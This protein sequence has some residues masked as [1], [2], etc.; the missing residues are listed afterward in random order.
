[1]KVN[2]TDQLIKL[3][4]ELKNQNFRTPASSEKVNIEKLSN[5]IEEIFTQR[6]EVV[7][8]GDSTLKP[9][10]QFARQLYETPEAYLHR[11]YTEMI[12]M[13]ESQN[14]IQEQQRQLLTKNDEAV[15]IALR[16]GL[17]S[18]YIG[19]NKQ[20]RSIPSEGKETRRLLIFST[21][22]IALLIIYLIFRK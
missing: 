13:R 6:D 18:E 10:I 14:S 20:K 3:L 8:R 22:F 21:T 16:T 15:D 4:F 17:L 5:Q 2:G 11:I 12:K 19:Q 7:L 9:E 1:M